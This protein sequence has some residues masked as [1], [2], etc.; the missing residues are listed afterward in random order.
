MLKIFICLLL[1]LICLQG[2]SF[3][4]DMVADIVELAKFED[5]KTIVLFSGKY[6]S[7][8]NKL[9]DLMN[10][11]DDVKSML[12]SYI[13][14]HFDIEKDIDMTKKYKVRTVPAVF[15]L[16]EKGEVE[17]SVVGYKGK[18]KFIDFLSE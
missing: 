18:E 12:L 15:I 3:S 7:W 16:D 1:S 2:I 17:K 13:V 11:D 4:Q 8:C 5:K 9:N 14:L 6:C 10:K